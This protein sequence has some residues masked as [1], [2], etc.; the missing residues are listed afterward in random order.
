MK[1][2]H[3]FISIIFSDYLA[4]IMSLATAGLL[5]YY[6]NVLSLEKTYITLPINVINKPNNVCI[7]YMK[8]LNIHLE[9]QSYE[10][11]SQ[12]TS[13]F[14]AVVNLSNAQL[15]TH[16]YPIELH[17]IPDKAYVNK[18]PE[19]LNVVISEI[20]TKTVP[21]V[22]NISSNVS[23]ESRVASYKLSP[24]E[25]QISGSL[26]LLNNIKYIKTAILNEASIP[27]NASTWTTNINLDT[28]QK[29]KN[30]SA[31]YTTASLIL[32]KQTFTNE[33]VVPV[34]I[35]K[36]DPRFS[37]ITPLSTKLK[38][39]SFTKDIETLILDTKIEADANSI[40]NAG[41]FKIPLN[42]TAPSNLIILQKE[43]DISIDISVSRNIQEFV[44]PI[45][46]IVNPQ[47]S[48]TNKL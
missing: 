18:N 19:F 23:N 42:I 26:E 44:G 11:I 17:N 13:K 39:I 40:S 43:K 34:D 28:P 4:K 45:I 9:V 38:V 6:V 30:S 21:V 41:S 31:N 29:L 33:I 12:I 1:S 37:S 22:L 7:N 46:D 10:D 47:N 24:S 14:E 8:D 32:K 16:R 25:I 2:L 36:L 35:V 3:R 48:E 15:G 5:W 27:E 20:V